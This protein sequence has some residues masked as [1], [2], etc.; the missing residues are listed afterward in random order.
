LWERVGKRNWFIGRKEMC[1]GESTE[2]NVQSR[3]K[4]R[5]TVGQGKEH[6][7]KQDKE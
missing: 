7:S 3:G 2:V 5:C 1:R 4:T 6:R